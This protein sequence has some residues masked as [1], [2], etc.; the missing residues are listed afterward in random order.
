[1]F[2]QN[3]HPSK[4]TIYFYPGTYESINSVSL[5]R[6]L[7][8]TVDFS[9]N[10][11]VTLILSVRSGLKSRSTVSESYRNLVLF[12]SSRGLF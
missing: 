2:H 6:E 3:T 12:W 4:T 7:L 9:R 5:T 10:L 1:M 11:Q 8:H